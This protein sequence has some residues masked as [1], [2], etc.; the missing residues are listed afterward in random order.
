MR[1]FQLLRSRG[2]PK[3][4]LVRLFHLNPP[5]PKGSSRR[6]M[7][8]IQTGGCAQALAF[9]L[10][11]QMLGQPGLDQGLVGHVPAVCLDFDAV[12]QSF[13]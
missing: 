9:A 6:F 10:L 4:L 7:L 12:E 8:P 11:V 1:M 13:G 2:L 5:P 3:S